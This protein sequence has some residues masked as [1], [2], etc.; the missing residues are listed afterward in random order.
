MLEKDLDSTMNTSRSEDD[1]TG[2]ALVAMCCVCGLDVWSV[3]GL[4]GNRVS[5]VGSCSY[6]P[7]LL[8]P[9]RQREGIR[10]TGEVRCGVWELLC[11]V[12][13]KEKRRGSCPQRQRSC[14][15]SRQD[16]REVFWRIQSSRG[17]RWSWECFHLR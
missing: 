1:L 12:V 2:C 5:R 17:V 6:L 9:L 8:H 13:E 7:C 3:G 16:D 15:L 10:D 4:S 11:W 14:W